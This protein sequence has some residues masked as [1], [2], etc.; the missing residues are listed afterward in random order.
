MKYFS[1][2]PK[3]VSPVNIKGE[4]VKKLKYSENI[5]CQWLPPTIELRPVHN[6]V[7]FAGDSIT[8]KCRAPSITED[9][10]ARLSWLWYPNTTSET[11]DLNTFL[12][13]QKSLSNI[14][15]DNRYLADSGIVDRYFSI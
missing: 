1:P 15:V 8:L 2:A 14:K 13:P 5:Q 4:F 11:V 10:N 6:Q 7:V 3:C 9:R 12:D